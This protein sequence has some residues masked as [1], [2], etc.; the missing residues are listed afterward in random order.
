MKILLTGTALPLDVLLHYANNRRKKPELSLFAPVRGQNFY[1]ILPVK[2]VFS[3]TSL[4]SFVYFHMV[5]KILHKIIQDAEIASK[6]PKSRPNS[7]AI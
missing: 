4:F 1:Q 3:K 7:G 5:D 2:A 6:P